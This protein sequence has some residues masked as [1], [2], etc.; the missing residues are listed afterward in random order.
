MKE[1]VIK[2]EITKKEINFISKEKEKKQI[3]LQYKVAFKKIQE[4]IGVM[5][6]VVVWVSNPTL[7]GLQSSYLYLYTINIPLLIH[8]K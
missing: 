3:K 1:Q 2:L 8:P 6:K 7:E 4:P 5:M